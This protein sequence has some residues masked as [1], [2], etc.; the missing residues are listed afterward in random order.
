MR[1]EKTRR[2]QGTK[3][4]M[5]L[6]EYL[7]SYASNEDISTGGLVGY[8]DGFTHRRSRVRFPPGVLFTSHFMFHS[9]TN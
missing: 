7:G 8:D 9:L 2:T 5:R 3:L 4:K 6:I 1:R